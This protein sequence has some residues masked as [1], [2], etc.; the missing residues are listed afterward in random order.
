MV[1]TEDNKVLLAK[2]IDPEQKE[3]SA[4]DARQVVKNWTEE[5]GLY[6][7]G[8]GILLKIDAQI[9]FKQ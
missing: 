7:I 2:F 3:R 4:E 8:T 1:I 6:G 9:R 5:T